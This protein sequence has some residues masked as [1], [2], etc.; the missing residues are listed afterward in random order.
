MTLNFVYI[1]WMKSKKLRAIFRFA[2]EVEGSKIPGNS[3]LSN[4]G[5]VTHRN[6]LPRVQA[7]HFSP[8]PKKGKDGDGATLSYEA[9]S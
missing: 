3:S 6:T 7:I 8:V 2:A 4:Q 5:R 1:E 9:V